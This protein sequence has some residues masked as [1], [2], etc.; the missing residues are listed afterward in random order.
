MS[1]KKSITLNEAIALLP[2]SEEIHTFRSGGWALIGCDWSK[3]NILEYL[4]KHKEAIELSGDRARSM[5]HGL[6]LFDNSGA[7]FIKT[8]KEKLD[9]FDPI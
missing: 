2:N 1:D 7:L 9:S 8:D 4:E 5:N 3:E 6:V